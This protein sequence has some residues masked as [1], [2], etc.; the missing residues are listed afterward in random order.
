MTGVQTCALPISHLH[1]FGTVSGVSFAVWAPNADGVSVVGDFN[2]WDGRLH[3][4][5][6]L[7]G[8][9][10][11]ELFIPDL[12]QGALYK[13]EIRARGWLPFLKTDPYAGYT[14]IPPATSSIVFKSAFKFRDQHW[15]KRRA[16]GDRKSVV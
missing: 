11:W 3:Q 5:R 7:G 9:G 16:E 4:M 6:V 15:L 8:S 2:G 12:Q 13:Y 10:V 14:E 1:K